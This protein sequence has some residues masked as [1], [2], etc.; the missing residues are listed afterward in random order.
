MEHSPR[1]RNVVRGIKTR[2]SGIIIVDLPEDERAVLAH[3]AGHVDDPGWAEVSPGELLFARPNQLHG[4]TRSLGEARG[5][6]GRLPGMFAPETRTGIGR[7]HTDLLLVQ[8]QG[9]SK[10]V[11]HRKRH[12]RAGPDGELLIFPFC[13]GGPG[14]H[15]GVGDVGDGVGSLEFM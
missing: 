12:L 3:A 9:M 6:D 1:L 13:Y 7:D 4:L 11:A 10:L 8:A 5:L 2:A 15:G 14:L